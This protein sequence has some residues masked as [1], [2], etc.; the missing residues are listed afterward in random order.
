[1]L[2]IKFITTSILLLL[3]AITVTN[4]SK[5]RSVV[6]GCTLTP[7]I[8]EGPYYYN[9]SLVRQNITESL[10]GIPFTLT[11]NVIDTNNCSAIVNAAVDIWH[12]NT[13]GVY[14]HF[15]TS[16]LSTTTYLRGIKLTD[17][18][19][20]A[21]FITIYPGYYG[22]RSTHIHVKVRFGGTETSS[23]SIY[24]WGG[25][26]SHTGQIFFND[27]ITT[28]VQNTAYYS[29]NTASRTLNSVDRVYTQQDGV[30]SLVTLAYVDQT[31]GVSGG[32]T[33]TITLKVDSTVGISS[34]STSQTST[35]TKASTSSTAQQ[36]HGQQNQHGQQ[37]QP[38]QRG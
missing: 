30:D 26:T 38:G 28:L 16:T 20:Q 8:E 34:S 31:K 11:L 18:N 27:S 13:V 21:K 37:S 14:S 10:N 2:S 24:Y 22:G 1:M 35:T 29:S 23:G 9:G 33:G 25:H 5:K 15:E 3:L 7:E 36:Q 12:C 6:S 17:T 32:L 4:G 19:G